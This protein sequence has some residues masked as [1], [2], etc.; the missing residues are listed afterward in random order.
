MSQSASSV[1]ADPC[2]V[3]PVWVDG[4]PAAKT[5]KDPTPGCPAQSPAPPVEPNSVYWTS[6]WSADKTHILIQMTFSSGNYV[7]VFLS[8]IQPQA[9]GREGVDR[10]FN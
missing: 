10:S 3:F 6:V 7:E 4:S 5:S 1:S 9:S 8:N 2:G